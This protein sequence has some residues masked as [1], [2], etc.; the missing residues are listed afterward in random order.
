M[1]Q[2]NAIADVWPMNQSHMEYVVDVDIKGFFDRSQS[3]KLMRQI[4]SM[5]IRD[6]Q[7]LLIIRKMLRAPVNTSNGK[8]IY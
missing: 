5:G 3:Y 2:Q 4:W 8:L 6:K 1:D 7:L